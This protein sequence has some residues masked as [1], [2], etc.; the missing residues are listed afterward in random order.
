MNPK[1]RQSMVKVTQ[2]AGATAFTPYDRAVAI[3]VSPF[4]HI[5]ILNRPVPVSDFLL[6]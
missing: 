4:A 1:I 6:T 5:L 3:R 2:P